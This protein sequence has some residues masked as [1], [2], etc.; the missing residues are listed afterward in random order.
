MTKDFLSSSIV[1]GQSIK[2]LKQ[3]AELLRTNN[4]T[5]KFGLKLPGMMLCN[6][7]SFLPH[8]FIAQMGCLICKLWHDIFK[9][10]SAQKVL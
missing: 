2:L 1:I 10:P 9:S 3:M 6:I 5:N 7:F 4:K 8:N